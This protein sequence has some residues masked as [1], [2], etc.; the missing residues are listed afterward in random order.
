MPSISPSSLL[1]A[2]ETGLLQTP[3]ERGLTL[4]LLIRPQFRPDELAALP[5]GHR[6]RML[7]ALRE[8]L[9]GHRLQGIVPC[10]QCGEMLEI[11]FV[12]G[13]VSFSPASE[14]AEARTLFVEGHDVVFRLPTSLDLMRSRASDVES[15]K[16]NLVELCIKVTF[17][18]M[19]LKPDQIP[20]GVLS[21]A[22]KAM[23][24]CDPQADIQLELKCPFC[25]CRRMVVFDIL[26]FLWTEIESWARRMLE[27]VHLLALAYGWCEEDIL[28]MSPVRRQAYLEMVGV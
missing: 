25:G 16:R 14:Q 6:D 20:E 28:D 9:F 19:T 8:R 18:G 1:S 5:L 24:D 10:P 22:I 13:D 21:A 7:L 17:E 2:W 15:L 4:L 12:S 23:G 3:A 27:E 26:Q 11:S